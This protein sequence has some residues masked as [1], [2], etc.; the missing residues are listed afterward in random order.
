MDVKAYIKGSF[1]YD[2]PDSTINAVLF[3]RGIADDALVENI[4]TKDRELVQADLYMYLTTIVSKGNVKI[5]MGDWEKSES[6]TQLGIY[7]RRDFRR[8]ANAIYSKYGIKRG[9]TKNLTNRW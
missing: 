4:S 9:R 2:F 8:M 1:G 6:S 5:K 3:A 7:D